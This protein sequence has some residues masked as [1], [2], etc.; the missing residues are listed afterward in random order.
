MLLFI[1]DEDK[2]EEQFS[3]AM[4]SDKLIVLVFVTGHC[5]GCRSIL[6]DLE[7]L[8]EEIPEVRICTLYF[9]GGYF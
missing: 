9:L 4:D 7:D 8:S 6:P 2:L 1:E 5:A 3:M